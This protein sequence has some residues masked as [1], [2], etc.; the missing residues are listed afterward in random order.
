MKAELII[1]EKMILD[2]DSLIEIR[3]WKV[4]VAVP[5]SEHELKYAAVYVVKN[6]RII[7]YDNERGKG[8]HRHFFEGE[9]SYKFETIE[10]LLAD[11]KAD[12]EA[13]RGGKI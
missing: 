10:K 11:F 5:P 13:V 3:V 7:G 4:P 6:K 1:H 8:D 9:T 2:A 12:V